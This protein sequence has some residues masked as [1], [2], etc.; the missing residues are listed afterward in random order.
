VHVVRQLV[1]QHHFDLVVGVCGQHGVRHQNAPG[2]AEAGERGVGL[3]R[4]LGEAPLVGAE[5]PR[6]GALRKREEARP[7]VLTAQRPEGE[8]QRQQQDGGEVGQ[9]DDQHREHR[10]GRRPPAIRRHANG[11]V[12]QLRSAAPEHDSERQRFRLVAS[13]RGERFG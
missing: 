4:L 10:A 8:K 5:N 6:A 2:A 13:P 9:A 3:G 11:P 12:D 7:Q 1:R